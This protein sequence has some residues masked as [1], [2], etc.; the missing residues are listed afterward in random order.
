MQKHDF[1]ST[2]IVIQHSLKA[3]SKNK[4]H[5]LNYTLHLLDNIICSELHF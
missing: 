2:Q 1:E 3:P 4:Q 5:C